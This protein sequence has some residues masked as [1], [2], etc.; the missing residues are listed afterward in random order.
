M[1][2]KNNKKIKKKRFIDHENLL[3]VLGAGKLEDGRYFYITEYYE[4]GSLF[5]I[6]QSNNQPNNSSLDAPLS[7]ILFNIRYQINV[8]I[9]IAKAMSHLHSI[10]FIHRDLKSMNVLINDDDRAV[11]I[12]FGTTRK[13]D[14]TMTDN[15]GTVSWMAPESS[16]FFSSLFYLL[17]VLLFNYFYCYLNFY[18]S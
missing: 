10:N 7:P 3:K 6:L 18:L 14:S 16:L 4:K 9:D 13:I 17:I 8:L 2:Q 11:V 5:K 12:D 1:Y 15:V